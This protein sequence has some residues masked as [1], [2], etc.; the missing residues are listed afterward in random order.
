[1]VLGVGFMLWSSW[2]IKCSVEPWYIDFFPPK[3]VNL[4]SRKYFQSLEWWTDIA[5]HFETDLT[6][7]INVSK[8]PP[9]AFRASGKLAHW[10]YSILNTKSLC[11][12][13]KVW[14]ILNLLIAIYTILCFL[15]SL[16][17]FSLS[18]EG[19]S[20]NSSMTFWKT[21]FLNNLS[22]IFSIYC[23][24]TWDVLWDYSWGAMSKH[25]LTQIDGW[26]QSKIRIPPK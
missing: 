3:F 13:S 24:T 2:F 14:D 1:M 25:Q 22:H 6:T 8:H 11:H 5:H 16:I 7:K 12:F 23:E 17:I 19:I 15:V 9:L 20:M 4:V 26:W 21:F 18:Q 10:I